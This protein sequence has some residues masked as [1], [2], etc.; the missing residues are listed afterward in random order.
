MFFVVI[1]NTIS[2]KWP[3]IRL[4]R[5][6]IILN[7]HKKFFQLIANCWLA[8]SSSNV[9][10][11][12]TIRNLN[13]FCTHVF[14]IFIFGWELFC[15]YVRNTLSL[16]LQ[17]FTHY[18]TELLILI[19][20]CF[21]LLL[22]KNLSPHWIYKILPIK[23]NRKKKCAQTYTKFRE[24]NQQLTAIFKFLIFNW[25]SK[26]TVDSL[27]LSPVLSLTGRNELRIFQQ[28]VIC[29]DDDDDDYIFGLISFLK[30]LF[31]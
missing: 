7:V 5:G 30:C 9:L 13:V 27:F 1:E 3:T 20:F 17:S 15:Y 31:V 14:E 19:G 26:L 22:V 25:L 18:Y 23:S 8:S 12:R 29:D 6:R 21:F 28:H 4:V 11:S 10:V 2:M 24:W 16:S